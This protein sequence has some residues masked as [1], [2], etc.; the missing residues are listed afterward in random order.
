MALQTEDAISAPDGPVKS[1]ENNSTP[2]SMQQIQKYL[3]QYRIEKSYTDAWRLCVDRKKTLLGSHR[4][5]KKPGWHGDAAK[6][7]LDCELSKSQALAA[8]SAR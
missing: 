3:V 7:Q 2:T 4:S 1:V 8:A 6:S 5:E